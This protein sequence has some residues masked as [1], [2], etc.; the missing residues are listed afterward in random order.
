PPWFVGG[1]GLLADDRVVRLVGPPIG[2]VLD[3]LALAVDLA[4]VRDGEARAA[5][6]RRGAV[7][8]RVRDRRRLD[9]VRLA[10]RRRLDVVVLRAP[11]RDVQLAA[12]DPGLHEDAVRGVALELHVD[13]A[14]EDRR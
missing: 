1:P 6:G 3:E 12:A 4:V 13:R 9:H 14:H 11:D 2:L 5:R 8:A 10:A 7:G